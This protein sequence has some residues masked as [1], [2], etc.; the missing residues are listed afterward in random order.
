MSAPFL[1]EPNRSIEKLIQ[2]IDEIAV[3]PHVVYKV[4]EQSG[5]RDAESHRMPGFPHRH[6]NRLL[7]S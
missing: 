5:V 1:S 3:L 6:S 2:R 7:A 4:L